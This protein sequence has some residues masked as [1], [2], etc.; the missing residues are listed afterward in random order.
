MGLTTA[1]IAYWVDELNTAINAGAVL[2]QSTAELILKYYRPR[3]DY[4][5]LRNVDIGQVAESDRFAVA[6]LLRRVF[7]KDNNLNA[8]IPAIRPTA[9]IKDKNSELVPEYRDALMNACRRDDLEILQWI[10]EGAVIDIDH[11]FERATLLHK[12][13][14][15]SSP[16]IAGYL[17]L[18]GA[19][20]DKRDSLGTTALANVL[21]SQ[22]FTKRIVACHEPTSCRQS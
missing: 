21:R 10:L 4:E 7:I 6:R 12:A 13:S 2:D 18:K 1:S 5:C 16:M 15:M 11:M 20:V 22:K 8:I 19:M 9:H 14:A 3:D 17:I